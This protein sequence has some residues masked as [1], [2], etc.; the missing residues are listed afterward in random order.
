M[1]NNECFNLMHFVGVCFHQKE[2]PKTIETMFPMIK[3]VKERTVCVFVC[4]NV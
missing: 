4:I 2:K 3:Q 1:F